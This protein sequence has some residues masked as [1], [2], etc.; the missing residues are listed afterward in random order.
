MLYPLS[1]ATL[2]H[3]IKAY[4]RKVE[5]LENVPKDGRFIV[6]SNHSSYLDDL[7]LPT[8]MLRHFRK[9]IHFYVNHL[10]FR[11]PA[12]RRFLY[13][14]GSIHVSVKKT[15]ESAKINEKAFKD[16]SE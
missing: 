6:A 14:A 13:G 15:P 12:M 9:K 11:N 3:L 10:Y 7:I 2:Y 4:I 1:K 16:R 8:V 5:G